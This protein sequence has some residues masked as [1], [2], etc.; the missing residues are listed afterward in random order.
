MLEVLLY[1]K[2]TVEYIS[3]LSRSRALSGLGLYLLG[4][5]S[6]RKTW[7]NMQQN[8]E[9]KKYCKTVGGWPS[10]HVWGGRKLMTLG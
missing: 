9:G 7:G 2:F 10:I 4:A 6:L 1:N 8:G 5:L 3:V